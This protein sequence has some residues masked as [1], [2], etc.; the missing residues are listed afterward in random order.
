[1]RHLTKR[2][3]WVLHPEQAARQIT[4]TPSGRFALYDHLTSGHSFML[5]AQ[6]LAD[7][8]F[9]VFLMILRQL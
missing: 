9:H 2:S 5:L 3:K 6:K 4:P 1:M 7:Q 8:S